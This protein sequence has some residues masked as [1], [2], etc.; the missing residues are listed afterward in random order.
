MDISTCEIL[1]AFGVHDGVTDMN[2]VLC[3]GTYNVIRG[4]AKELLMV[5]KSS[6][7]KW[8]ILASAIGGPIGMTGYAMAVHY[9]G[10]SVGAVASA[11]YPAI[12]TV[13]PIFF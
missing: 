13:L 10:A 9:M 2:G 11:V 8:L 6:S 5:F 4:K 3:K 1:D 12:G 7:I